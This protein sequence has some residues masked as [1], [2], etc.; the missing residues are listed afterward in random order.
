MSVEMPVQARRL[1]ARYPQVGGKVR[2][3]FNGVSLERFAPA[4]PRPSGLELGMLCAV[5]PRKRV[6]E[7]L[8]MLDGLRREQGLVARLH[9]GGSWSGDWESEEY[10]DAMENLRHRLGLGDRVV[11]HGQVADAPSWL[12]TIDV[13]ISNAYREGQQ[14]ALLEAMAAGCWCLSHVWD[15]ADEVLPDECLYTTDADLRAKIAAYARLS[16]EDRR[17]GG[18]RM[19]AIAAARFDVETTRVGVRSVIE[20][21]LA[22]ASHGPAGLTGTSMDG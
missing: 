11:F 14:V 15:G 8:L 6:Y 4:G 18:A 17:R 21:A 19:R 12:R 7:A 5:L 10:H 22:G 2:V 13:F 3:V 16:A 1:V 9:V 20:D